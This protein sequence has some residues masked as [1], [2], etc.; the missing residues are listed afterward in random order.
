MA[1]DVQV[2]RVPVADEVGKASEALGTSWEVA[3]VDSNGLCWS[4]NGGHIDLI[5][6]IPG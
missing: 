2:N 4:W 6:A 3:S 1:L 5:A